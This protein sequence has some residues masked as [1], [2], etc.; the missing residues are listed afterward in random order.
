MPDEQHARRD[1][2]RLEASN[3]EDGKTCLVQISFE[4]MHIV[5]R[6]GLGHAKECGYIVPMI[7][8]KPVAVFEGL[9]CDED[10][11]RSGYGWRCYCGVPDRGYRADGTERAPYPGQVYLVFVNSEGIAYNWRWEKCDS[12]DPKL[13]EN[14]KERF[15]KRLL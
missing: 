4:R 3:P 10:E 6:R 9:R 14:Y 11:D 2:V 7:L 12:Q 13:P 5:G 1:F 8:Q 15:R